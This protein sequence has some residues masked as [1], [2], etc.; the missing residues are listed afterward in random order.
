M[1]GPR[2]SKSRWPPG[3]QDADWRGRLRC[4]RSELATAWGLFLGR[5]PWDFF[6]TL[7]FD[8]KRTFP[9]GSSKASRET[10]WWLGETARLLRREIA[11]VYATERG[12]SGQWHA[13]ALVVGVA[14]G[15]GRL[16][17]PCEIWRVRN[18]L[19]TCRPV[20]DPVKASLYTTEESVGAGE[21][22]LSDTLARYK[23]LLNAD[24][25]PLVPEAC[26]EDPAR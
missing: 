2:Y 10:F 13:H 25:L 21:V 3:G 6:V 22:V 8:P 12:R 4:P 1:P 24:C 26:R 5:V 23:A 18:G 16:R 7:T 17:V 19:I 14:P 20:A 9:V 11:W 15:A